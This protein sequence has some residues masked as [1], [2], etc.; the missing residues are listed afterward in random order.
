MILKKRDERKV[1]ATA[2]CLANLS[3]AV[4]IKHCHIGRTHCLKTK[5][6]NTLSHIGWNIMSDIV[7][8]ICQIINT[9]KLQWLKHLWDRRNLFEIWVVRA[10]GG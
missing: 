4:N 10:T 1:K 6:E 7:I 8:N 3:E 5:Y 2:I 9:V